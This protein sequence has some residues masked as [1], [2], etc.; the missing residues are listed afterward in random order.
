MGRREEIIDKL[1]LKAKNRVL[2][3]T[4]EWYRMVEER[5]NKMEPFNCPE[6][7]PT[8]IPVFDDREKYDEIIVKNLIR[9]GAIPKENLIVGE[10]YLGTCRNADEAVWDGEKF[11]YMRFK[12]G[13][14]Q[15]DTIKHFEDEMYYDVFIPIKRK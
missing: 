11:T 7:C 13:M 15:N 5:F 14:F 10:T 2:P 8:D 12:F 4:D 6:D 3:Y 1:K 9:C